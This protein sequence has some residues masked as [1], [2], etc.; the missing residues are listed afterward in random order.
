MGLVFAAA[1]AGCNASTPA[2]GDAGGA[3]GSDAGPDVFIAFWSTFQPF[4]TW[5]SFHSSG[6]PDDG[7]FPA[8]VLG[9]RTQYINRLPPHGA[10]EF[11]IGTVIVEARE[12]GAKNLF[13]AVKRGFGY[14][15][16]GARNWEWFELREAAGQVL[17]VWRGLGPPTNESYGGNPDGGC[18]SC[19]K[20]CGAGNDYIC[21]P[22]LQLAS[23]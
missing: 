15:S 9:P 4:R 16:T 10:T 23:F 21:S 1:L 14:N 18:N 5:K 20:S 7:T 6:P 3:A 12:S 19:H 17:I 22:V 11:P 13:A 8:D 2:T